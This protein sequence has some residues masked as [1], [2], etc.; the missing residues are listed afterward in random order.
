MSETATEKNGRSMKN[1]AECMK[2]TRS[3]SSD[4]TTSLISENHGSSTYLRVS[5]S[6][7]NGKSR[8]QFIE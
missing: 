8:V 4:F 1:G 2:Q 7:A 6:V 5:K 3:C